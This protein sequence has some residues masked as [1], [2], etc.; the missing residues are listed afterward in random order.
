APSRGSREDHLGAAGTR[1]QSSGRGQGRGSAAQIGGDGDELATTQASR[2]IPYFH[3]MY[4]RIDKELRF[5]KQLALALEQG[6]TVL[7]FQLDP[8]GR[9]L[10]LE[11]HK[12]SGFAEFD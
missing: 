1:G 6:E 10:A 3:S 8:K 11:I 2:S 4:R 9:V 5:P 7:K 12:G